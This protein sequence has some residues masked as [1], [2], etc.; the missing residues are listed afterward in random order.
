M[1]KYYTT[2]K[3]V[4]L[5]YLPPQ[6]VAKKGK[7]K[8]FT[9]NKLRDP[10]PR[11]LRKIEDRK[12]FDPIINVR[13]TNHKKKHMTTGDL[14]SD[15]DKHKENCLGCGER[16][17]QRMDRKKAKK[18]AEKALQM[19]TIVPWMD[20]DGNFAEIQDKD[21]Y[22]ALTVEEKRAY[23]LTKGRESRKKKK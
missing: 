12:P 13:D 19:E 11:P 21:I 1:K 17:S 5:P 14:P 7:P 18:E 9:T 8:V 2:S 20:I 23:N 15:L 4:R 6:E 10:D 3:D 16:S 22:N